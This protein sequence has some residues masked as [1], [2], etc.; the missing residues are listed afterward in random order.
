ME[1]PIKKVT[2]LECYVCKYCLIYKK[3]VLCVCVCVHACGGRVV[4]V[5]ECVKSKG[6]LG[7]CSLLSRQAALSLSLML[8]RFS[9]LGWCPRASVVLLSLS[10]AVIAHSIRTYNSNLFN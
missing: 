6:V 9:G 4:G 1:F 7:C 2:A 10:L 8:G 3:L 5:L